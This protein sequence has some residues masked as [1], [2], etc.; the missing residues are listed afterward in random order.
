MNIL[1]WILISAPQRAFTLLNIDFSAALEANN[2]LC[3]LVGWHTDI[4]DNKLVFF[5]LRWM[6]RWACMCSSPR[7]TSA[8]MNFAASSPIPSPPV[9]DT[10]RASQKI[11]VTLKTW[12]KPFAWKKNTPHPP[13]R[14]PT[15]RV[16][17]MAL[18]LLCELT[19][20]RVP[21]H[22]LPRYLVG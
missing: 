10:K 3:S 8:R 22:Q 9:N 16:L 21:H 13:T 17:I 1:C 2:D 14:P 19:S 11:G 5:R 4:S 12:G 20:D 15:I 6:I 7:T 18:P